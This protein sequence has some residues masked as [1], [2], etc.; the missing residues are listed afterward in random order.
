MV[1]NLPSFVSF[2]VG[3]DSG[4]MRIF[5]NIYSIVSEPFNSDNRNGAGSDPLLNT[6][7]FGDRSDQIRS[8]LVWS[9]LD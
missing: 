3:F 4:A 9:N 2:K 5:R 6:N 8:D 7:I 1:K